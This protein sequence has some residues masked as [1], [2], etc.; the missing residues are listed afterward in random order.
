[1]RPLGLVV[2]ALVCQLLAWAGTAT[3]ADSDRPRQ[4]LLLYAESRLAPGLIAA[5]AAFR[6]TVSS[7]FSAPVDFRTEFL[8]LPPTRDAAYGRDLR[9][10]LQLKYKDV[11]FDLVVVLAAR[12]LRSALEY[13]AELG[14]SVPIV[15]M[16][17]DSPGDLELPGDVTGV[18]MTLDAMD[19]LGAALRLQPETRRVVVVGGTSALDKRWI[20]AIQAAF[21]G[22]PAHLEFTYLTDLPLEAAASK[23]AALPNGTIV[24]LVAFQR[25]S[26]GRNLTS[27]EALE[28]LAERSR[29]PIYGL[30]GTYMGHGIVGGRLIDWEKQGTRAGELALRV[31]RGEKL[32]PADIVTQNTNTFTFDWRQLRRWGLREDRLPSGSVILFREPSVWERYR[33][34]IVGALALILLESVLIAGLVAQRARRKR[35]EAEAVVHLGQLV[36]A[37][38]VTVVGELAATLAHEI[39]QPLG[40]IVSNA[41]SARRLVDPAEPKRTDLLD[42]LGDIIDDGQRAS[43]V[44]RRLRTMLRTGVA[45]RKPC[46]VNALIVEMMKFLEADLARA[47]V[48]TELR[49]RED[50]PPVRG[51][52]IQ[53]Q[54]VILNLA[55][56]AEDAMADSAGEPRRLIVETA[57]RMPGIV[58][59]C[60]RDTGVGVKE[61][62]LEDIF[63]P[64]VTTKTSGLGMGLSISRSIVEAHGGTIRAERN[65]DR[66]LS[67]HVELP[68]DAGR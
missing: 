33:W 24:F 39:N 51:D 10:L 26:T 35:A 13:R 44:I 66:G 63:K 15:F 3:A 56:N 4:V 20:A 25:D 31:L 41:E 49:L 16:G 6:S 17:V 65:P 8:D 59:V 47:D 42:T 48:S 64:F 7:G 5:D 29:V 36:H 43:E 68:C 32:G 38:R 37:Q 27:I 50:L 22:A 18:Q 12:A 21:A 23:L 52:V 55:L 9:D 40:A 54:Q 30:A 11:H 53:L 67:I 45:E 2:A 57:E 61:S 60:V 28:R 1:M 62:D 34:P 58:E 19:T 14:P 46:D